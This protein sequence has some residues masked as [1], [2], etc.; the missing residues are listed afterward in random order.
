MRFTTGICLFVIAACSNSPVAP[1]DDPFTLKVGERIS[2]SGADL[3]LRFVRVVEDSRCPA[4]VQCIRAGN[5]RIELEARTGGEVQ[6]V[7]LNTFEGAKEVV[8]GGY[9]IRLNTLAPAPV[10][11]QPIPPNDYRA[12][13]V[14]TQSGVVCTEEARPA[15]MVGLVDSLTGATTFTNVKIV[16]RDGAYADSVTAATYPMLPYDGPLPLAYERKGTYDVTVHAAG[17]APWTKAGV[18]VTADQCHVATVS[19]T[20]RLVR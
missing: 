12:S 15:L 20:A 7:H 17:Y 8:V 6:F 5:G 4:S 1:V 18:V 19:L 13:L 11:S 14:V 2:I 10:A 16:A 3:S 9:R